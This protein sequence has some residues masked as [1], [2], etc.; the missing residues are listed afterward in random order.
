MILLSPESPHQSPTQGVVT[1]GELDLALLRPFGVEDQHFAEPL[2]PIGSSALNSVIAV[3]PVHDLESPMWQVKTETANNDS[4]DVAKSDN[5]WVA[6]Y[7]SM[8]DGTSQEN[9]LQG[10][11]RHL[12]LNLED[13]EKSVRANPKV[14]EA[15]IAR[16]KIS[17]GEATNLDL[18]VQG[19]DFTQS[20]A[21]SI[22]AMQEREAV[23]Q[24]AAQA[25]QQRRIMHDIALG[26]A[27][28]DNADSEDGKGSI[29]TSSVKKKSAKN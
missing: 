23:A 8:L 7:E 26:L 10:L 18:A 27:E 3:I 12:S 11:Q 25:E 28:S 15:Q 20:V 16:A 9:A 29:D 1:P 14:A 5:D 13:I 2:H 6:A 17:S 4:N 19:F 21:Q 24:M 22:Q